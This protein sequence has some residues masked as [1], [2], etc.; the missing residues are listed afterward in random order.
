MEPRKLFLK[1]VQGI[2]KCR[3]YWK[4]KKIKLHNKKKGVEVGLGGRKWWCD[5]FHQLKMSISYL[6]FA[7]AGILG[8]NI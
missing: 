6:F 7:K 5:I 2:A 1:H 3:T 4:K 8:H